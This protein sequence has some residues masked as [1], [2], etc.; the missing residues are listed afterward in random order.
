[1]KERTS[2]RPSW[3]Q[4]LA[5][6]REVLLALTSAEIR[7][8]RQLTVS[9]IAKWMLEPLSY[10]AIYFVVI[11]NVLQR[12]AGQRAYLLFLLCALVPFTFFTSVT[13]G[14]MTLVTRYAQ[15]LTNRSFNRM[16]LPL[17]IVLAESLTF[18]IGLALLVPFM[19]LY[20][21]PPTWALL[22]L[23]V[24][25]LVLALLTIGPAYLF[26]IFG[27]YFPDFRGVAQNLLRAGFFLS[28]G[29]FKPGA[30]RDVGDRFPLLIRGNPLSGIFN[31][32]R[33]AVIGGR[34][35][36]AVDILYP[37]AVALVVGAIGLVVYRWRRDELPKEV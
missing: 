8:E 10:M 26:T 37:L 7:Q 5:R 2:E 6:Q 33:R 28:T 17:V 27:L 15:A 11:V 13:A 20:N 3:S 30:V 16:L 24:I 31:A 14:S 34:T 29:L 36:R 32:T 22:W 25:S 9:G 18:V 1:M 23:P 12:G 4:R 19:F 35:P 21:T